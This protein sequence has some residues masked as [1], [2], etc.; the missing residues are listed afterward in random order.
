[1]TGRLLEVNG[2]VA[3]IGRADVI[4]DVEL[5][6][7]DG[8]A[9]CLLGPNGAGKTTLLR[10][11][12]GLVE[13]RAG[14]VVL[15]GK[16]ITR[17]RPWNRVGLGIAH[18][19]QDRRTFASLSVAEN[20]RMGAY[21]CPREFDTRSARVYEMFPVLYDKREADAGD[22]SGGQ[23]QMLAVGRALMSGPRLLL[24]DE[25]TLGLAPNL[26][27]GLQEMLAALAATKEIA[28]LLVEQNVSLAT[29]V[30]ERAY[31]LHAGHMA[32]SDRRVA[33]LSDRELADAY[34]GAAA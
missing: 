4:R 29:A 28:L 9:V 15:S 2:L 21:L 25:P 31:V 34:L 30:C 18:V 23:Q 3:R 20:L 32:I 17:E 6:V 11:I 33:E 22:L 13:A 8:E 27:Q 1:V 12:S 10:T 5:F 14:A 24:L 7:D 26:V 16:D 19:P